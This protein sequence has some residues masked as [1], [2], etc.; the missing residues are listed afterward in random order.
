MTEAVTLDYLGQRSLEAAR[1]AE[2]TALITDWTVQ[3]E[4]AA[5]QR[6]VSEAE[7]TVETAFRIARMLVRDA[8]TLGETASV[9]KKMTGICDQ[10]LD[11]LRFLVSSS[12][13]AGAPATYDRVLEWRHAAHERF[14][15]HS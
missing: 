10:A 12:P 15:L 9:W 14:I 6:Q 8:G 5:L 2:Q 13:V 3:S 11:H 4:A 1:R 7:Q